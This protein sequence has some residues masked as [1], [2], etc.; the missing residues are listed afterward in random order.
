MRA[1]AMNKRTVII[2]SHTFQTVGL[3]GADPDD[4]GAHTDGLDEHEMHRRRE[5]I[6]SHSPEGT[7]AQPGF[8]SA[9]V[10]MMIGGSMAM[11][12]IISLIVFA[13]WGA[14]AGAMVL[15]FGSALAFFGNPVIWA[16]LIRAE[17]IHEIEEAER[18]EEASHDK[19]ELS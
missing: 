18:D 15:V 10:M 11:I 5:E 16:L 12:V 8:T 3:K 1:T 2:D 9:G 19:Q 17:E 4:P 7:P 13:V 6:Y 14:A